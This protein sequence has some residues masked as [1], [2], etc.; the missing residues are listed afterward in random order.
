MMR[1]PVKW[2]AVLALCLAGGGCAHYVVAIPPPMLSADVLPATGPSALSVGL[3]IDEGL[4]KYEAIEKRWTDKAYTFQ[5]GEPLAKVVEDAAQAAFRRVVLVNAN[6]PWDALRDNRL[7]RLVTISLEQA[8]VD[9]QSVGMLTSQGI[10]NV[11]LTLRVQVFDPS[12]KL[13]GEKVLMGEG[14]SRESAGLS[15]PGKDT[16]TPGVSKAVE[17]AGEKLL[18]YFA[19]QK[20]S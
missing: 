1:L 13:L 16:F 3:L 9:L 15:G 10:A 17:D 5:I 7:D 8:V 18:R 11:R 6:Q 14:S 19:S 2:L 20:S 12:K 4:R